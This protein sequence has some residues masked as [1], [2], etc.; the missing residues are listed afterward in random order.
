M[1]AIFNSPLINPNLDKE[2]ILE[3]FSNNRVVVIQDYLRDDVAERIHQYLTEEM[4]TDWWRVSTAPKLNG[5]DGFDLVP[6]SDEFREQIRE[7]YLH[8]L[9][10]F[11]DGHFSY[12]FHRTVKDHGSDCGC[13]E[14]DL[15]K[16]LTS[17]ESINFLNEVIDIPVTTTD[18]VFAAVYLPGDYLSPHVDSP[19]GSVGFVYQLTKNWEPQFG[20]NLHFLNNDTREV[21]RVEVPTFNTLTLFDLPKGVGK[22]HYVSHVS[23]GVEELRLTYTGWYK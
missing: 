13:F 19:N 9:N 5:D 16:W 11:K 8:S 10:A 7:N 1:D 2:A 15:R 20:G 22:L 6:N 3:E 4:P 18:E 21:E 14:C 12:C 23:P 17:N